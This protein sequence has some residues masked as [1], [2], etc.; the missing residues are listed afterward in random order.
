MESKT[1]TFWR[2]R[3]SSHSPLPFTVFSAALGHAAF[4]ARGWRPPEPLSVRLAEL[5]NGGSIVVPK[6]TGHLPGLS[7]RLNPILGSIDCMYL[8]TA[9]VAIDE[10]QQ[11]T[12]Q[13]RLGQPLRLTDVYGNERV[14]KFAEMLGKLLL[15]EYLVA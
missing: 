10:G 12:V 11:Q 5:P 2:S 13:F 8:Y 9:N 1:G 4:V 14:V 7:G 3:F 15:L 6:G